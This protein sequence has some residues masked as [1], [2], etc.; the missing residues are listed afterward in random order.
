VACSPI[1]PLSFMSN[2]ASVLQWGNNHQLEQRKHCSTS[3]WQQCIASEGPATVS[4]LGIFKP[5]PIFRLKTSSIQTPSNQRCGFSEHRTFQNSIAAFGH[6]LTRRFLH[7]TRRNAFG[8]LMNEVFWVEK[9][10][11]V[12]VQSNYSSHCVYCADI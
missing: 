8:F 10:A 12:K 5:V 7:K 4:I 9:N 6:R 11:P 2:F 1:V 3:T